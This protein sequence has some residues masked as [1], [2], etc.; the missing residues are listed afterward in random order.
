MTERVFLVK[1]VKIEEMTVPSVGDSHEDAMTQA[2]RVFTGW[3]AVE[4]TEDD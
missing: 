4:A 2:E 1:L 3:E